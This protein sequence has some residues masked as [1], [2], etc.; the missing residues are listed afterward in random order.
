[1]NDPNTGYLPKLIYKFRERIYNEVINFASGIV[2]VNPLVET[3]MK[4]QTR[5]RVPSIYI[6]NGHDVNISSDIDDSPKIISLTGRFFDTLNS[7]DVLLDV[8]ASDASNKFKANFI[9]P[10]EGGIEGKLKKLGIT[11][12]AE[13]F[14]SLQYNKVREKL[15]A[16]HI[17]F[18]AMD[19]RRGNI[20]KIPSKIWDFLSTGL[21]IV[22]V[23]SP[24][25]PIAKII[26][27]RGFIT[28]D[29]PEEIFLAFEKAIGMPRIKITSEHSWE[30]RVKDYMSFLDR[31]INSKSN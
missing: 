27:N 1:M 15:A 23:A 3:E 6:P 12:K 2:T 20:N 24:L 5:H 9:G 29:K 7:T 18:F 16:S 22:A 28:S 4:I 13:I 10:S 30:N 14:G 8:L 11:N 31:V 21:P 25:S 17:H 19:K 26:G